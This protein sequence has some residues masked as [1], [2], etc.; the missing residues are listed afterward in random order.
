VLLHARREGLRRVAVVMEM[1]LDFAESLL[2]KLGETIEVVRLVL[3]A[4]EKESVSRRPTVAISKLTELGIVV[5][6]R[7]D[8]S[9]RN[10]V[11]SA[12]MMRLVVVA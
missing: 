9:L 6:P 2:R 3:L 4:G 11:G 8:T 5:G 7:V 10:V 1:E 12:V